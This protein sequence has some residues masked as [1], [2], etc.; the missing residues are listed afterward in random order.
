MAATA[1]GVFVRASSAN[2]E[3]EATDGASAATIALASACAVPLLPYPAARTTTC[4]PAPPASLRNAWPTRPAGS[5]RNPPER[6]RGPAPAP[7]ANAG[8]ALSVI[9][10]FA[11]GVPPWLGVI[12]PNSNPEPGGSR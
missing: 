10:G 7:V 12:V 2:H 4:A 11:M 6:Y 9:D 1:S 3:T 5:A 8:Y